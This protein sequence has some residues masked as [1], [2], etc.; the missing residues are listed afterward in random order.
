MCSVMVYLIRKDFLI[1]K[2]NLL[3][4]VIIALLM[5]VAWSN[6]GDLGFLMGTVVVSYLLIF[7]AIA[8][9]D[10]NNSDILLV[11]LPISR[12]K[13]VL[14]K[15]VSVYIIGVFALIINWLVNRVTQTVM[16]VLTLSHSISPVRFTQV[17]EALG[18][19]SIFVAIAF[20]LI[21]RY[22]YLKARM[23]NLVL[24]FLFVLGTTSIADSIE[25]LGL[26]LSTENQFV[27]MVVAVILLL[28][29]SIWLSAN[30]YRKREY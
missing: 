18:I 14:A 27:L 1:Q 19:L 23:I 10:K 17:F 8:I 24:F 3:V 25:S 2:R 6:M 7:G 5:S 12:S 30:F 21:F 22:G 13:I 4:C 15:Y 28:A 9:E 16:E 29:I 20:P 11:S 26:N